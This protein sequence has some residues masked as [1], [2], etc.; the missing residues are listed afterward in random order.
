MANNKSVS[1]RLSE[2]GY[3]RFKS[4]MKKF[5]FGNEDLFVKYCV[6]KTIKPKVPAK[7]KKDID[8]EIKQIL[9]A[10]RPV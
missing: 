9:A 2:R 1:M 6:L 10:K 7:I 3:K 5:G 8:K 4:I